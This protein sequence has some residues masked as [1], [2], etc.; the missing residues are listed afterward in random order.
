[1]TVI[2]CV[3][4]QALPV[5]PVIS[6]A[7]VQFS[8]AELVDGIYCK[9]E[10]ATATITADMIPPSDELVVPA[11]S[12]RVIVEKQVRGQTVSEQP[13]TATIFA[14]TGEIPARLSLPIKLSA[15]FYKI[16]PERLNI[17][18]ANPKIN[19]PYRLQFEEIDIDCLG[20][21]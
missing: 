5:L 19:A 14:A 4:E 9:T 7:N 1:M 2:Q 18:L 17:G 8:G 10:G 6:V 20:A 12:M 16:T 15:G 21:V 11:G 3:I 13:F